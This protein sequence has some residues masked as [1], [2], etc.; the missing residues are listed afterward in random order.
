MD[1]AGKSH[2][3]STAAVETNRSLV[4]EPTK[5]DHVR[6]HILFVYASLQ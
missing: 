5:F 6:H 1:E 3:R 2:N 4:L